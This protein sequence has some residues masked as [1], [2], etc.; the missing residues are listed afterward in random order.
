MTDDDAGAEAATQYFHQQQL[1]QRQYEEH[2]GHSIQESSEA[3]R[4]G[5]RCVDGTRWQR[6]ELHDVEAS[7]AAGWT[8]WESCGRRH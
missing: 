4:E 8:E 1:E 5:A 6:E 7:N 2:H 3:R